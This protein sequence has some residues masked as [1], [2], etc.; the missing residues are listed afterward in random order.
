[1]SPSLHALVSSLF[2]AVV[3]AQQIGTNTPEVNPRL[4]WEECTLPG[5]CK[6]VNGSIT[7]DANYRWTHNVGGYTNCRNGNAWDPTICPDPLTCAQNCAVEGVDYSSSGIA[8]AG[9]A[10][11]L[12]L[13][14]VTNSGPRIYLLSEDEKTYQM[15]KLNQREFAFDVDLSQVAC[16]MNAAL[17]F[18]EM[19]AHGGNAPSNKAGAKFGTGYCDAQ[20]PSGDN[21]FNGTANMANSGICCNEMDIWE[22]NRISN[23]FTTHGCMK[24]GPY[25]CSGSGCQGQCDGNGCAFNA[26]HQGRP[27]FYGPKMTI[28]TTK[29]F[30]VVTQ[31][32]T[33]NSRPTG[34]L[35]EIRRLYVQNGRVHQTP[36]TNVTGMP[37]FNSVSQQY[38][39]AQRKI[40]GASNLFD[41]TGG[42]KPLSTAFNTGMVLV[43]SLWD[44]PSGGMTWLDGPGAGSC[45]GG[46]DTS[47][48]PSVNVTFSNIKFGSIGS[49]F[50]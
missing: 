9:N 8:T 16:G 25:T 14:T 21:F 48:G 44:D 35:S 4:L 41:E 32:L 43:F 28:D 40:M 36:P 42:M 20:C 10:V 2:V 49:T 31:F 47:G 45:T 19:E 13:N 24:D 17:Y 30:T 50:L 3:Y 37:G 12:T 39:D 27:D 46:L 29:K 6:K 18:S 23:A 7:I 1:M 34:H 11:T 15:F 22:A 33:D 26:F 5:L 38:C